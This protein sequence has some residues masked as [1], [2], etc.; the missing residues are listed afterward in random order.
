MICSTP[1]AAEA[2]AN[3]GCNRL[4]RK[5]RRTLAVSG[6]FF[7]RKVASHMCGGMGRRMGNLRNRE[8]GNKLKLRRGSV[9]TLCLRGSAGQFPQTLTVDRPSFLAPGWEA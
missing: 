5:P 9:R 1:L 6:F 7:A 3:D 2:S 8:N 4:A